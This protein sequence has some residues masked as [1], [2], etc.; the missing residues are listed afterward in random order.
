VQD[1][2]GTKCRCMTRNGY[3]AS[4]TYLTSCTDYWSGSRLSSSSGA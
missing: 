4:W 3:T 1:A 2:V